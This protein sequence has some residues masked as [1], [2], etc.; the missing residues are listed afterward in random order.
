MS[1]SLIR[2]LVVLGGVLAVIVAAAALTSGTAA[3]QP[4]CAG[5]NV[6]PNNPCSAGHASLPSS[7]ARATPTRYA[8]EPTS[9]RGQCVPPNTWASWNSGSTGNKVPWIEYD[10]PG[11]E[12]T[13]VSGETE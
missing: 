2:G 3:A 4:F 9:T 6:G 8:S 12:W 11:T 10:P 1:N 13:I 7:G 5:A